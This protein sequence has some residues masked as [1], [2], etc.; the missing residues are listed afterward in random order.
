MRNSNNIQNRARFRVVLILILVGLIGAV[1]LVLAPSKRAFAQAVS[2]TWSFTGN[3]NE[4]RNGHTATRLLNGKVLVVGGA[5]CH[6]ENNIFVCLYLNS[7][8]LYDP[9]S[10]TWSYTG[11]L[12]TARADHT[13]ALL[14]A[15]VRITWPGPRP[16]L[17]AGPL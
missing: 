14:L 17:V 2:P 7:A 9:A 15:K 6:T 10:G 5:K 11:N 8:E 12:N 3:L 1:V 4:V 13:A 16:A